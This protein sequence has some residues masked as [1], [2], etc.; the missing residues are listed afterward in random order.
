MKDLAMSRAAE[1]VAADQ[2]EAGGRRIVLASASP[3][4]REIFRLLG[5]P[6]E[7]ASADIDEGAIPFKTPREL[8]LKTAYAKACEIE[9]R[10][11][12]GTLIVAADTVV[13]REGQVYTKP[14]DASDARRMLSDLAG[15]THSV[16]T[17]VAVLEAG[18]STLMDA[19]ETRVEMAALTPDQIADYVATGE[20]LDKA[21]AYAVQGTT[22][23]VVERIDGDYFNVVGLPI[24]R[25]LEMLAA[26][27][28][29]RPFQSR[30]PE[31]ERSGLVPDWILQ[32]HLVR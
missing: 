14:A 32:H 18:K 12:T 28:D 9:P 8:A 1:S 20:P 13:T 2:T 4:R 3:R 29:V 21:G 23:R 5:I 25:V 17:G 31:L 27:M 15:R 11:P 19:V 6:H 7:I 22:H 26:S 24:A 10:F 30:L 16:I